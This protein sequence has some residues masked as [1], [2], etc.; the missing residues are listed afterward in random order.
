MALSVL[1]SEP[2]FRPGSLLLLKTSH[3]DVPGGP[4]LRRQAPIAGGTGSIS[5][6]GTEILHAAGPKMIIIIINTNFKSKA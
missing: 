2:K 6:R 1:T 3:R 5:G 4:V